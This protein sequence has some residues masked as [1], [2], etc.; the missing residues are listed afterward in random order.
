MVVP[1]PAFHTRH[2]L[3]CMGVSA[4]PFIVFQS[5]ILCEAALSV[6]VTAPEVTM[7]LTHF[8]CCCPDHARHA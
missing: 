4:V 6:I 8:V 1:T 7:Q 3:T 5:F 2:A